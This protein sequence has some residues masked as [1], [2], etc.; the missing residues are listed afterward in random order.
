MPIAK[1][2]STA[3]SSSSAAD[4]KLQSQ[5]AQPEYSR[6]SPE[7]NSDI[8]TV[9]HLSN[10][11]QELRVAWMIYRR[12]MNSND[13]LGNLPTPPAPSLGSAVI[14]PP[15]IAAVAPTAP[16]FNFVFK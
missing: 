12:E 3:D 1:E 6:H 4:E 7:V 5:C 10:I 2:P 11:A 8:A 15:V 13:L 14:P 16:K 9:R